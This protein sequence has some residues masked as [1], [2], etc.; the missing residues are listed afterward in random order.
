MSDLEPI[1]GDLEAF[2]D[3]LGMPPLLDLAR[4]VEEWE[5]LAG[6]PFSTMALPAGFDDGELLL[7]V[8]DGSAASIMKYR[9]GTL[10]DRLRE[11]LGDGIV[12]RIRIR[13]GTAK[14]GL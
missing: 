7:E 4:L 3:R 2:L 1:G 9:A 10:L 6:E 5:T 11:S 8:A 13:V 12:E 14:K